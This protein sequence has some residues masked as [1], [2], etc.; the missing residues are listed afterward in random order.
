[1]TTSDKYNYNE[2]ISDFYRARNQANLKE[3]LARL[4]GE[5]IQLLSYDEVRQKLRVQGGIERGVQDIPLNAIVGSVGRYSD[6][7]R[8]FLPK[9]EVNPDR[10]ARIKIAASGMVGLP[11]ID[12]YKIGEVYFVKDGNHRVS[13]A[14]DL[15]ATHIQ[16]YVTEVYSR[17]PLTS[18]V[19]LDDLLL[20]AEY[21]QFLEQTHL[22]Q[23][24]PGA[25][26]SVTIPGQ[27]PILL[28]HIDV[29]R[30]FMGLDFKRDIPYDEAITHW[31]DTVYIPV[32]QVI[33]SQGLL[34]NFP[35]RTEADLYLWIARHRAQLEEQLGWKIRTE[36]AAAALA[37]EGASEQGSA[38]TRLGSKLLEV[39]IPEKLTPGPPPGQWRAQAFSQRGECCL[40][41]D[42]LVPVN[43]QE[44]GWCALE[45]AIVVAVREGAALHGLHVVPETDFPDD[46]ETAA[47][48][49]EFERR[50]QQANL[51][52]T[53]VTTRGE[54]A[55]Q[56]CLHAAG[57]DL[58]VVNLSHPPGAQLLARLSSGF[59]DLIQHCPRPILAT[60]QTA[61]PLKRA[62]LAFDGSPKALEALYLTTYLAGKWSLALFV[63][64][65]DDGS[66][67]SQTTLGRAQNY[68]ESYHVQAEYILESGPVA[69][70]ILDTAQKH[71]CDLII[72]GG[73]GLNPVLEVVMGSTVD[74]LLRKSSVPL[75]ICR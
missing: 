39:I 49:A 6:F 53:L 15:G 38:L 48:R 9:E 32:I 42:I 10:W 51:S 19:Q 23:L 45:Q 17:V 69:Q 63:I 43:G 14:R 40:F 56:T 8:D 58:V 22:N 30:Y 60:P 57:S 64:S 1:M 61:A 4:T 16:A 44:D 55:D 36:Y 5:S 24:R 28:E 7:T 12:V 65:V 66:R 62:L 29:H 34:R 3:L 2:A 75:L 37:E 27:Y 70:V 31:Y 33:R 35:G 52:G 18:D 71:D 20:K 50:C 21:N 68:L 41:Q 11:P 72:C 54:V 46:P 74:Q 13:V 26:L 59:H 47:I 25:D 73:Y 67:V